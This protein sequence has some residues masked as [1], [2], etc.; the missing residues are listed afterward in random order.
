MDSF[1]PNPPVTAARPLGDHVKPRTRLVH[2]GMRRSG[3]DETCEALFMT[4]G[5]VYHSAEEAAAAFTED[6]KRFVYSRYRNPTVSTFEDRLAL[7]EGAA[8]CFA[9]SSG[10][11]AV[12][13]AI[14]AL[15]SKGDRVVAPHQ[16]FGSSL[17]ILKDLAPR[18]GIEAELVDGTDLDQW[19]A[20][21]ARPTALVLVETPTNPAMGIVDIRA[22]SDLAHQ[23]GAK[24]IVDNVFATPVLQRPLALGAD[25]I[26]YST[27]KHIDGQGRSLGGAILCDDE[28]AAKIAPFVRHTGPA[29]SP[30]NAWLLAKGLETLDLRVRA[31]SEA[32][33]AVARIL[34]NHPKVAQ[35][36][37]PGLS[38]H[39]QFTLAM[40]QMSAG[41]SL[42]AFDLKDGKDGAFRLMNGLD[43]ILI[44]NNLGDSKSLITHPA[45]TTH[46]RLSD[47]EKT[48]AG[49]APGTLRLSIGL[50]D[51]ADLIEDLVRGLAA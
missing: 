46:Q 41:G 17:Y 30:F 50:E 2:G 20:A 24:V 23:A 48:R 47:E 26:V 3:F 7:Y 33:L 28:V 27:T 10:M 31:Q 49:I 25:I 36:R 19:A 45:T 38:S 21:L 11:A 32:A 1:F 40:R 9:V 43:L 39:P 18:F 13:T 16:L 35:V 15:V 12:Y 22:V 44:S 4:S 51:P 34:E 5:Y 29:L 8:R 14:M 42:I 6:G 37:Y